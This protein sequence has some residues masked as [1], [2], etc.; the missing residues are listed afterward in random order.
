MLKRATNMLAAYTHSSCKAIFFRSEYTVRDATLWLGRL[1]I[2]ELGEAYL[3]KIKVLYPA[4]ESCSPDAMEAKWN[5]GGPRTVVFCGRDYESKNGRMALKIFARLSHD[6]P[7]DRFVYV[8]IVPQEELQRLKLPPSVVHH[9]SLK[10]EQV[11]SL[12]RAS[13]ILFHPS[14]FE[15]L[16]IVFLEAAASG[17]A[18]VTATGG[19]MR[20]VEEFFATGGAT[21]I[22]RDCVPRSREASV[23]ETHLR[24]MLG[25]R[26][27]A[28]SMARHNFN[29]ATVGKLSPERNRRILLETYEDALENPAQTPLTLEQIPHRNG[30]LLRFSSSQLE[31]L[32]Q[33]YRRELN[34]TQMR[35][36]L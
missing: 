8:G 15:G 35:F 19:A 14:E 13:H 27:V 20:H 33:G 36:L 6:F 9:Q 30:A 23:F 28:R 2:R 24:H 4:Q 26:D 29:L 17:M 21:L 16:G 7:A 11:L 10:H 5:N 18:V 3:S 31:Q 25:N 32:G 1:G 12:L 34:V 22:D